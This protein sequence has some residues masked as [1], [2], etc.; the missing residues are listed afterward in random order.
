MA[1]FANGTEGQIYEDHYCAR[2][3]HSLGHDAN[4]GECCPVL[5]LHLLWN[6]DKIED[7]ELA[8]D[9]FIPREGIHNKQCE[10][11]VDE[12]NKRQACQASYDL[13][14]SW[15]PQHPDDYRKKQAVIKQLSKVLAKGDQCP[16]E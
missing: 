12:D 16:T 3:I 14:V 5:L 13:L 15:H 8:L 6:G 1:Y 4:K 11:F 7:R 10:M 2:C 9:L